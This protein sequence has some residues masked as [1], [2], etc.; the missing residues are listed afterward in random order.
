M[1]D[2]GMGMAVWVRMVYGGVGD[3]G[4]GM[5]VWVMMVRVWRYG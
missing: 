3:D 1:G 4:M 5:A 2:D